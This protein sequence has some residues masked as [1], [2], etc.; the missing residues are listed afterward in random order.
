[1]NAVDDYP[2]P[3]DLAVRN[4]QVV[5]TGVGYPKASPYGGLVPGLY[6]LEL[7]RGGTEEV[8]AAITDVR[9]DSVASYT[10]FAVGTL[11][12]ND[13]EIFVARDSR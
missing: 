6:D 9:L 1:V 13:V 7:H 12:R 4:G 3:L 5:V 8:V 2:A 10:A 11:R